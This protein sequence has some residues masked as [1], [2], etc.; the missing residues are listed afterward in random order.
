MAD[1]AAQLR[2]RQASR[3]DLEA[4]ARLWVALT[5][6]HAA[7]DDGYAL[8]PGADGEIRRLLLAI[9][10]DGDSAIWLAEGDQG[11]VGLCAV[12]IDAAPPIHAEVERAEITDLWVDPS[13]RRLGLGRELL[14][15]ALRWIDARGVRRVEVRVATSNPEG[16]AFWRA[17][18][19]G[20]FVD[21]LHRHL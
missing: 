10:H 11:A 13:L 15:T 19:F 9:L 16:Q 14:E 20:D 12:R 2:V 1:A 5:R 18:G 4:V 21:V 7:R 6:H 3:A 17:Q 8:L